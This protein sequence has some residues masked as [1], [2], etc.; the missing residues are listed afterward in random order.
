[1]N[2]IHTAEPM[3]NDDRDNAEVETGV[4]PLIAPPA[5]APH[6]AERAGRELR[7]HVRHRPL[8]QQAF[9]AAGAFERGCAAG[10]VFR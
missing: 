2:S 8:A 7:R 9:D 10:Q 5:R 4:E 3:R 6:L 1:L